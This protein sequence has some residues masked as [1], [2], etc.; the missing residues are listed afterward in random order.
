M[1]NNEGYRYRDLDGNIEL[2]DA[3]DVRRIVTNWV[4]YG[5]GV[6]KNKK[7]NRRARDVT[8]ANA[9]LNAEHAVFDVDFCYRVGKVIQARTRNYT[10][11][12]DDGVPLHASAYPLSKLLFCAHCEHAALETGNSALRSNMRGKT[13]YGNRARRY[14]HNTERPCAAHTRSVVAELVERDFLMLIESLSVN[15]ASLPL[16]L[17]AL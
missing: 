15:P 5:G 6:V 11:N 17:N 16:L 2:F 14:R 9:K 7:Q 10:H 1:L 8:P 12:P 3:D 13:G 4:E